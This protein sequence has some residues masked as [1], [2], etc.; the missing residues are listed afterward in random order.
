MYFGNNAFG[1]EVG[2]VPNIT[3]C[4]GAVDMPQGRTSESYAEGYAV[5]RLRQFLGEGGASGVAGTAVNHGSGEGGNGGI[6]FCLL[7]AAGEL[8][9]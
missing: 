9:R 2:E 1:G 7:T 6:V 8:T 3:I 4:A 5:K